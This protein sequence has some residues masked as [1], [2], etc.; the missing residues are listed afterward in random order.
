MGSL[1][2]SLIEVLLLCLVLIGIVA[3]I[4]FSAYRAHL[5]LGIVLL[6]IVWGLFAA[7]GFLN[8]EVRHE[9]IV[10]IDSDP[11]KSIVGF[12]T[13]ISMSSKGGFIANN[14]VRVTAVVSD[15]NNMGIPKKFAERYRKFSIMWPDSDRLPINRKGMI[16]SPEAGYV[17]IDSK[18]GKGKARIMFTKP[19]TFDITAIYEFANGKPGG[20]GDEAGK[21]G[22]REISISPPETTLMIRNANMTYCLSL[23]VLA[24]MLFEILSGVWHLNRLG[25]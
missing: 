9:F 3:G 12:P 17:E 1:R 20:W 2:P 8:A 21:G 25:S 5:R 10:P 24:I 14:E 13:V 11:E 22:D 6:L 16:S 18:T 19:G 7:L 4:Y 15:I 23:F